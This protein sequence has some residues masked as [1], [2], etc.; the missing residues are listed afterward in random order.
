MAVDR[1]CVDGMLSLHIS[2]MGIWDRGEAAGAAV[3][4]ASADAAAPVAE[5]VDRTS[6][7]S[8]SS[9][10][11]CTTGSGDFGADA[12]LERGCNGAGAGAGAEE[13]VSVWVT[14]NCKV[15]AMEAVSDWS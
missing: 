12:E 9:H 15:C 11:D 5:V 10:V 1:A 7:L 13:T 14:N 8:F 4:P 2:S 6:L 3:T